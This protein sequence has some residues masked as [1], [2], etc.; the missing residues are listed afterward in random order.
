MPDT[1]MSKYEKKIII[2]SIRLEDVDE[3]IALGKVCFP[4]MEPW[5]RE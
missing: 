5:K 2:R 1:D 4:N 3:I